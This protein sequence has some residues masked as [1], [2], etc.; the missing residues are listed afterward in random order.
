MFAA[1][2]ARL[3]SRAKLKRPGTR[4]TVARRPPIRSRYSRASGSAE[5][6]S[7]TKISTL[8]LSKPGELIRCR[9]QQ[10]LPVTRRNNNCHALWLDRANDVHG[11]KQHAG[12]RHCFRF[13]ASFLEMRQTG[14]GKRRACRRRSNTG[15][16]PRLPGR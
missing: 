8:P 6:L 10:R 7:T 13:D 9:L 3:L 1:S 5:S 12:R 11:R 2:A 14:G 16:K 4:T 15:S